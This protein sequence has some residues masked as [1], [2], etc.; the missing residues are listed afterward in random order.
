MKK[1]VIS[2]SK[3]DMKVDLEFFHSQ[4]KEGRAALYITSFP[5]GNIGEEEI[6]KRMATVR[7]FVK[8]VDPDNADN[9]E[10]IRTRVMNNSGSTGKFKASLEDEKNGFTMGEAFE[11]RFEENYGRINYTLDMFR[12]IKDRAKDEQQ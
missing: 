10:L 11:K 8:K 9:E 1:K 7:K 3:E 5:A 4:A 12:E 2:I 6:E